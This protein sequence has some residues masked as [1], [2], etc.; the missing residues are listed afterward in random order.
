MKTLLLIDDQESGLATRKL[1]LETRGYKVLT[2]LS[3]REGLNLLSREPVDLLI[4]DYRMPEM[5]GGEVAR[6]VKQRSPELPIILLSGVVT[7]FPPEVLGHVDAHLVKGQPPAEL[8]RMVDDLAGQE[9]RTTKRPAVGVQDLLQMSVDHADRSRKV[10]DKN[11]ENIGNN[12]ARLA[13]RRRAGTHCEV[14]RSG[15]RE[16]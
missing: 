5:D 15:K 13:N 9:V 2:A 10:A 4:L 8:L 3:G 11:V 7:D 1:M 12:R 14:D 6:Q 16:A